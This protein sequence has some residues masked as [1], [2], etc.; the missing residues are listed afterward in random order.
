VLIWMDVS[1]CCSLRIGIGNSESMTYE[2]Q[3]G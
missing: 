1:P 3:D 2:N